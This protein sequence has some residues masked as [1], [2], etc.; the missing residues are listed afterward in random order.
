MTSLKS[1]KRFPWI[2]LLIFLVCGVL[3]YRIIAGLGWG[4]IYQLV[5]DSDILLLGWGLLTLFGFYLVWVFK[6]HLIVARTKSLPFGVLWRLQMAGSFINLVTPTARLGG[7]F[8]RAMVL[9]KRHGLGLAGSYGLVLADQLTGFVGKILLIGL[10]CFAALGRFPQHDFQWL[11][12]SSGVLALILALSWPWIRAPLGRKLAAFKSFWI[13]KI[14]FLQKRVEKHSAN[15]GES[16][17]WIDRLLSPTFYQGENLK[18]LIYDLGLSA[19]SF[20]LFCL[21]NSLVLKAMGCDVS[22]AAMSIVMVIGYLIGSVT[23]IMGGAGATEL[24]LI[25]LYAAIGIDE[26]Q[27]AAG[28]LVHRAIFYIFVLTIGG[29]STWRERL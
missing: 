5:L 2:R 24:A 9:E 29:Y 3:V 21:S 20:A 15:N 4:K 17:K 14:P 25:Q 16:N 27:A 6:W 28:A 23:G 7:G 10:L 18:V 11:L 13:K 1:E 22:L 19:I 12:L 8:L 26:S